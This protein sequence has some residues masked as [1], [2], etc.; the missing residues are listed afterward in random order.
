LKNL[1]GQL[2]DGDVVLLSPGGTS[3]DQFKSFEHRGEVFT[4]WVESLKS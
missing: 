3:V 2:K 1:E 4:A